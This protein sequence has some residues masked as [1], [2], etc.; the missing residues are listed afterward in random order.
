MATVVVKVSRT[1]FPGP[2]PLTLANLPKGIR[3]PPDEVMIPPGSD[4]ATVALT[5]DENAE[6]GPV[7]FSVAAGSASAT[8][9]L[10]IMPLATLPPFCRKM[11]EAKIQA[12]RNGLN[13]YY[14]AIVYVLG[15]GTPIIFRWVPETQDGD[16]PF[17]IMETKVSNGLFHKFAGAAQ[18]GWQVGV[19]GLQD[20]P[21]GPWLLAAP[22]RF[23][24]ER[25]QA[26]W[27]R[28]GVAAPVV[29][30][31]IVERDVGA[32]DPA[33]PVLRVTALEAHRFARWLGCW[34]PTTRE[35]DRAAGRWA[36]PPREVPFAIHWNKDLAK[37]SG[38]R[39]A[40]GR[41][42]D[43]PMRLDQPTDDVSPSGCQHMS[44]NGTEWTNNMAE[45][46]GVTVSD[47]VINGFPPGSRVALRG[48]SYTASLPLRFA[49][50]GD[51]QPSRDPN[52]ASPE[53]GFRVVI[54]P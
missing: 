29:G 41:K 11:A 18:S 4:Q 33:L 31:R 49:K 52:E 35:W 46:Q 40:I 43:G 50:M 2:I 39:I 9:K 24:D 30:D 20:A 12:S 36:N 48:R 44:G 1:N 15:D 6:Q 21:T 10:I 28:G 32:V 16:P 53:T 37:N 23:V 42:A 7:E 22:A 5:I 19:A 54:H 3:L 26:V 38:L 45:P 14:S 34:L 17:Y 47:C 13:K 8:I 51:E 25:R 27:L